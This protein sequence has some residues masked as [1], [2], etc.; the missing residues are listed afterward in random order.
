[1]IKKNNINYQ[2]N[3]TALKARIFVISIQLLLV[4]SFIASWKVYSSGSQHLVSNTIGSNYFCLLLWLI[5]SIISAIALLK[6]APIVDK[7][8]YNYFPATVGWW[9][10]TIPIIL[11]VYIGNYVN[12]ELAKGKHIKSEKIII[13]KSGDALMRNY[14]LTINYKDKNE[15]I[16]VPKQLWN[17]YAISDSISWRHNPFRYRGIALNVKY[18]QYR[19]Q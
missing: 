8:Q 2:S 9:L 15:K 18:C 13:D 19:W 3:K 17:N 7:F 12:I 10:F 14:W 16:S 4:I 1:M 11:T 6:L 5:G